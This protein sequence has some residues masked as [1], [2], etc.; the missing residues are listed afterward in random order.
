MVYP[1]NV[2]NVFDY[3]NISYVNCMLQLMFKIDN[4]LK[5]IINEVK[6]SVM[7]E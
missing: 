2:Y 5:T 4:E 6:T 1:N 3:V 7:N